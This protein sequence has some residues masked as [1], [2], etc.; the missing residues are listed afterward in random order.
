M[1]SEFRNLTIVW[2]AMCTTVLILAGV[3]FVF[4]EVPAEPPALTMVLML[5][6]IAGSTGAMG[7]IGVPLF[8]KHLNAQSAGIVRFACGESVALY[9]VVAAFLGASPAIFGLFFVAS[10]SVLLWVRPTA[11]A[12]TA[13][14]MR[15]GDSQ[16]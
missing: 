7:V 11:D 5:A 8:L 16:P 14:E 13:W 9:G 10:L 1:P 15:R 2:A 12:F 4:P 6:V 3:S